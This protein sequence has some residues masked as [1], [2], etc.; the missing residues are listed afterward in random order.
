VGLAQREI[1]AAGIATV[2][3][4]M[5]PDFTAAPGAPRV[6]GIS[7]PLSRPFGNPGDA[8]GQRAILRAA[9]GV[10]DEAEQPGTVA[11]LP[12]TWPEPAKLVRREKLSDPPPIAKLLVKKPWLYFK[13]VS[14]DIPLAAQDDA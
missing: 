4:S 14:G 1:E 8:Q 7:Y 2:S 11:T 6:A 5:I 10:L 12:F 13:L 9:L 3:L